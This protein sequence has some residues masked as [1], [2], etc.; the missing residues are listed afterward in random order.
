MVEDGRSA[1]IKVHSLCIIKSV[2]FFIIKMGKQES[3]IIFRFLRIKNIISH[4][5]K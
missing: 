3:I 2:R 1:G 5:N 4:R